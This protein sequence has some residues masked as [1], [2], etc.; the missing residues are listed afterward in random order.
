MNEASKSLT[1]LISSEISKSDDLIYLGK[2]E[3]ALIHLRKANEALTNFLADNANVP[4]HNPK[5]EPIF[6]G[7]LIWSKEMKTA[8][9]NSTLKKLDRINDLTKSHAHL[10]TDEKAKQLLSSIDSNRVEI[11]SLIDEIIKI[12]INS[13]FKIDL[14][15]NHIAHNNGLRHGSKLFDKI[16][17]LFYKYGESPEYESAVNDLLNSSFGFSKSDDGR[18]D[19]IRQAISN[20]DLSVIVDIENPSDELFFY[21][22]N[23]MDEEEIRVGGRISKRNANQRRLCAANFALGEILYESNCDDSERINS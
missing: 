7:K 21:L 22:I 5:G 10:Q 17:M 4:R 1:G 20:I 12:E 19:I 16:A 9:Q 15:E 13:D 23:S 6:G 14:I 3:L 2:P 11:I 8:Y 18:H